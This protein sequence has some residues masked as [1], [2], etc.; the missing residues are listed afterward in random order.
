M[1]SFK[2]FPSVRRYHWSSNASS[3]K[4]QRTVSSIRVLLFS[5]LSGI[6][7]LSQAVNLLWSNCSGK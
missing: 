6:K 2:V 3:R 5:G 7:L 4:L 1:T